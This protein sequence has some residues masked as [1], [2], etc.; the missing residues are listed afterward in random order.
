MSDA[1]EAGYPATTP[2]TCLVHLM[3][4]SLDL[5]NGKERKPLAAAFRR[6]YTAPSVEAAAEALTT[7]EASPWGQR[8]PTIS[9][10]WRRA[11]A[12]V[13]PF[14]AFPPE[15]RRV[16]GDGRHRTAGRHR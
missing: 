10:A 15:V 16:L 3:R 8:C 1:I 5:A 11:W 6:I 14:F 9:K 4:Q 13:I 7:F 2:Q 12:S